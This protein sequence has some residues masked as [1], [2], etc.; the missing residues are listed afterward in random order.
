[1]TDNHPAAGMEFSVN[2]Q[3]QKNN[4]VAEMM[5]DLLMASSVKIA[6]AAAMTDNQLIKDVIIEVR[7]KISQT[8]DAYEAAKTTPTPPDAALPTVCDGKEQDAFE[9]WAKGE[10]MDVNTHPLHWLFLDKQT[11]AAR[12]GWEA[13]LNYVQAALRNTKE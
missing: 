6:Y 8:L 2:K 1:M 9:E 10:K 4:D 7:Q 12:R 11:Y 5:A 13:A 3:T